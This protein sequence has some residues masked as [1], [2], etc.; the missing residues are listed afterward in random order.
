MAQNIT[1]DM[2]CLKCDN[3][4]DYENGLCAVCDCEAWSVQYDAQIAS[5][6][7]IY[8]KRSG[9]N[10]T[11]K[12]W[13]ANITDIEAAHVEGLELLSEYRDEMIN[14]YKEINTHK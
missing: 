1:L 8:N 3:L 2:K 11:Y 10:Y 5:E 6:M 13:W 7:A 12:E 14:Y 4:P 9:N